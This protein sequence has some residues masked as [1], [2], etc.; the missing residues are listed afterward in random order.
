MRQ[1]SYTIGAKQNK[2]RLIAGD[3][4]ITLPIKVR[5]G[6]VQLLLD[7]NEVLLAGTLI[8]KEGKAVTSTADK[9]DVFGV[10]Y[11]DVSFKDSMSSTNY[12]G[13]A[14]EVVPIFVHGALYES[15]VKFNEDEAIKKAEM[16]ALK[17][18]IFGE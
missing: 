6:D 8:T 16:A 2:L 18:I 1:S 15:A 17:Q 9:T 14:T 13:D 4:F 3:H 12:S 5:K 7:E 10:V 11:Q